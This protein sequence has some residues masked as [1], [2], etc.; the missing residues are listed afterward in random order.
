MTDHGRGDTDVLEGHGAL[1]DE[2]SVVV[3]TSSGPVAGL[4]DGDV[5]VFKGIPYAVARRFHAPE[6]PPEWSDPRD[7]TAVGH[8]CV[9]NNPDYPVWRDPQPESEDCLYL[10][11]W[12]P[13]AR[14]D[15]PRPVMVWFHGGGFTFGSAGAPGYDAARLSC[16][17]DVVVVSMNHRL[18]VFGYLWL[19]DVDGGLAAHA[20]PGQRD[21]IAALRWIQTNIAAFGG[22]PGNVTAFGQS[23][24]GA[25]IGALMATPESEGLFHK[26]IIQSG[27]QLFVRTREEA[28]VVTTAAL[29][30][31]GGGAFDAARLAAL[32]ASDLQAAARVVE[33]QL[34]LLAFQPVVDGHFM[35]AQS[36]I[37]GAPQASVGIPMIIGTTSDEGVDYVDNFADPLAT[38]AALIHKLTDC[39]FIVR[40]LNTADTDSLLNCYREAIGR[41]TPRR[42]LLAAMVSDLFH[43]H[44]A[45]RQAELKTRIDPGSV[46][47]YEFGWKTPCFRGSWAIHGVELP[48]LLGN[49]S[50]G[51]AWDGHDNDTLRQQDDPSG[52][53]FR[54]SREIIA[55]WSAFAHHGNPSWADNDWAPYDSASRATMVFG[56][57]ES[58]LQRDRNAARRNIVDRLPV[59]W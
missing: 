29:T 33:A 18:N 4:R 2:P 46:F 32:P 47:F 30:A 19:G 35:P 20:N 23:G 11:V 26:A 16:E 44:S 37:D 15:R 24:G 39:P 34:G 8:P 56:R 51:T 13:A 9:Q 55:A 6:A 12:S 28:N 17:G 21:L 54:L 48:F 42:E 14:A 49:L 36:W 10:N 31:L 53:R 38:D 40:A 41:E 59:A 3:R 5:D 1:S 52:E 25:K 45:Q 43:W 57:H 22:D 7:C 50:Y 27:S 58:S